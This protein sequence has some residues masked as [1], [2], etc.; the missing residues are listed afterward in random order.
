MKKHLLLPALFMGIMVNA[1]PV[2]TSDVLPG[3]GGSYGQVDYDAEGFDVGDS[4]AGVTWDFSDM[5]LGTDVST[6]SVVDVDAAPSGFLFSDA[7]QA[8]TNDAISYNFFS[9]TSSSLEFWGTVSEDVDLG[10]IV[11]AYDDSEVLFALPVTYLDENVDDFSASF[12]L[13]GFDVERSGTTTMEADAYGTLI[14]PT[15]TFTDV[16]RVK[17]TQE[18]GDLITFLG[19]STDY[20][21]EQ[22]YWLKVGVNGPVMQ[23]VYA[24]I[25]ALG[26]VTEEEIG[27]V[28]ESLVGVQQA[29]QLPISIYP[30]PTSESIMLQLEE[31]EGTV[32][33]TLTN[34][35][36]Q[37]CYTN[38]VSGG[39]TV[40][41]QVSNLQKGHYLLGVSSSEGFH[42]QLIQ[43]N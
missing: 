17:V 35:L 23:Y 6:L 20:V 1:Q 9:L 34:L 13:T 7:N 21:F 18:Y 36:G 4:G 12:S 10:S 11:I 3:V 29:T 25:D 14:L 42:H 38:Q 8:W 33:I 5:S 22:Y 27:Y 40:N 16:L 32:D 28:N 41:V 31:L 30:N 24:Y 43:I 15:G 19:L 39:A 2:I 26:T 37:T